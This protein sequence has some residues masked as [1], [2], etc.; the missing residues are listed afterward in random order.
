MN[1]SS[2]ELERTVLANINWAHA[3]TILLQ[4]YS[5]ATEKLVEINM[6]NN[7][8]VYGTINTKS[9]LPAI[10]VLKHHLKTAEEIQHS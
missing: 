8:A 5:R 9:L 7:W 4:Q 10:L 1:S 6:K 3:P 2:N